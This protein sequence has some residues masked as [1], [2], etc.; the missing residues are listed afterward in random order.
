MFTDRINSMPVGSKLLEAPIPLLI[1]S[2]AKSIAKA[3]FE[4]DSTGVRIGALLGDTKID[5]KDAEGRDIQKSLLDMGFIPTFYHFSETEIEVKMTISMQV[6]ESFGIEGEGNVGSRE[7]SANNLPVAFGATINVDYHSRFGFDSEGSSRVLTKLVARPAPTAFL[8]S[9][10]DHVMGSDNSA[11]PAPAPAPTDS[12]TP[13]PEPA[14][15]PTPEP[16]PAP[17]ND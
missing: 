14:P 13:T 9:L 7:G 10:R 15:E 5:L 2:L 4:L 16:E 11:A 6:E 17:E 3:Q 12:D 1:E 8:D